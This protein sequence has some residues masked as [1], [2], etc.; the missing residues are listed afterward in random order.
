MLSKISVSEDEEQDQ[1]D[2]DIEI[3]PQD[4]LDPIPAPISNQKPKWAQKLIEAARNGGENP[5][6]RRKTR[7]QYQNKSIALSHSFATYKV[8]QQNSRE[9][10]LDVE[11]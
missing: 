8:V 6:D 3:V 9:M 1:H 5:N 2:L 7:S 11:D 10:L 4:D